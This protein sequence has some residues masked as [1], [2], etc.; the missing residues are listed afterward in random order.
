MAKDFGF[1]KH[2]I[3]VGERAQENCEN[4]AKMMVRMAL[5]DK[6]RRTEEQ[7]QHQGVEI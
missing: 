6:C 7:F 5:S 1:P 3:D 2:D 4:S